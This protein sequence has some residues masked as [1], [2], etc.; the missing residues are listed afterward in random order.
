MI[1]RYPVHLAALRRIHHLLR[2]LTYA[3]RAH[4]NAVVIATWPVSARLYKY[5]SV[6]RAQI[7]PYSRFELALHLARNADNLILNCTKSH[8]RS[9]VRAVKPGHKRSSIHDV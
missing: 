1:S 5:T 4:N 6:I 8:T 3:R 9:H 7:G 2:E